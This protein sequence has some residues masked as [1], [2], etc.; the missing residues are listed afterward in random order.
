MSFLQVLR[1]AASAL[2]ANR[3]RS[4]LTV[5]SI[6][7]GAFAIVLMT[8]LAE[9]GLK[10]L[11][12]GIEDLGGAR[13]IMV[14]PK[15]PERGENKQYAYTPGMTLADRDR[16]FDGIPHVAGV[17][18]YSSLGHQEVMAESGLRVTTSVIASD[19][20]FFS[21]FNMRMARG[22]IFTD[23]ENH[24]RETS[25]IVGPAVAA[26]IG[27]TPNEPLGRFLSVGSLRC[28]I[29]G[30]FADNERFGVHFGFDWN[31]LVVVPSETMGDLDP[32][33]L[34]GALMLVQTDA[35]SANPLVVRL[36]NARLSARHPGVDDFT[37]VDFSGFMESWQGVERAME[38]IVAV[39]AGIALFVGGVGVMNMMLVAVSE[40]VKEIGIRKALGAR[41]RAIGVQFLTEAVLLSTLGGGTG[42]ALGLGVS[43]LASLLIARA[44]TTWQLS[45][46][47]WAAVSALVVTALIGI[48]F[49]WLPAKKAAALDPVEAMRR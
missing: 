16:T 42:V 18:M 15:R 27:P 23:E 14:F 24:A 29:T 49:G 6:T 47:P 37:I 20:R 7:I 26:K 30:V 44:V 2:A 21:V 10:T 3:G 36:I 43:V 39:L 46:A 33:V 32:R 31:D 35:V 45:L 17:S 11:T 40:R 41:P 9:S 48:G 25:C 4:I 38:L 19:T 1:M 8:S 22:R 13:I 28:R 34:A 12:K 5:L